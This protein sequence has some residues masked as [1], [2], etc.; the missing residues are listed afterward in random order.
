[1]G[2]D[3]AS[4]GTSFRLAASVAGFAEILRDSPD[5]TSYTL[6]DVAMQAADLARS[7]AGRVDVQ[8]FR[9]LTDIATRLPAD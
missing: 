4:T 9:E 5:A 3:F 2:D 6:G 7:M 1:M 8:E